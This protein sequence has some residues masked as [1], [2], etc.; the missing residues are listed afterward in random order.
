VAYYDASPNVRVYVSR[1]ELTNLPTETIHRNERTENRLFSDILAK[2][3]VATLVGKP[4]EIFVQKGDLFTWDEIHPRVLD[5][6]L[7]VNLGPMTPASDAK[8]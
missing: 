6:L 2:P 5:L 3:G 4:Y 7:A 8:Q 1:V